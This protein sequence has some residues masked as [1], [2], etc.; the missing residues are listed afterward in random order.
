MIQ[1]TE[2]VKR[3]VNF[4]KENDLEGM[5]SFDTRNTVGDPMY[6]IYCEDG[7]CVDKCDY[8]GYIEI[9]GLTKEEYLSLNRVLNVC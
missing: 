5:Q 4:I 1:L 9:F 3:L 7:I 6:N 8:Y 2:R